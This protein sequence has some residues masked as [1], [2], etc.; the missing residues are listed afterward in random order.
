MQIIKQEKI[1][2]LK[3]KFN[4]MQGVLTL[5]PTQ[6]ILEA[7]KTGVGG[8]GLLGAFLKHKVEKK[9]Y[10]FSLTFNNLKTISRGQHGL[11]KNILEITDY[12]NHQ[13]RMVV[14]NYSDW[15]SEIK[16]LKG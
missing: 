2:Y 8:F 13:Y 1:G 9:D 7:H 15:E 12:N 4:L 14:Q 16:R 6:L 3:S 11:Q 10:G 5:T